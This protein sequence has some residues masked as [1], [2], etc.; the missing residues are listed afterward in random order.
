[1]H[2]IAIFLVIETDRSQ[3]VAKRVRALVEGPI[4][5]WARETAGYSIQDV[6]NKFKKDPELILAWESGEEMPFMGQL[7]IMADMFKRPISDFYLPAPPAERPL[8][9]DFR[10]PRG[11]IAGDYSPA[12]RKQ[13]RFACE[14][15]DITKDLLDD[16]GDQLVHFP[17]QAR[18]RQSPER[19][20]QSIRDI[21]S[22]AA[23]EQITWKDPRETLNGW[24]QRIEAQNIL[25][26]Q[27]DGVDV[28]EA[29][30]FSIVEPVFPVIG[31]NKKLAPN[32]RTFTMLHE[33]THLLMGRSGI[34]DIDDYTQRAQADMEVE[35][36]C[37][38]AAAA[39]LMPEAEFRANKTVC[40]CSGPAV[41][42]SDQEIKDIASSFGV[43]R[44]AAVRRLLTFNLTTVDFYR[45]R[46]AEYH[47][48]LSAQKAR[49][50]EQ[51]KEKDFIGQSGPQRAISDFGS[52]YVR[53]ILNSLGEQRIT[54]ADAA[55]YLQVR[56]PA[57]RKVQ[58]LAL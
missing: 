11:A 4:L 50:R 25:V 42:W 22:V 1:Q 52:N 33:F 32:G 18:M 51:N 8:P 2:C 34:C 30:G 12:L 26:F 24:R 21:L 53:T 23:T 13:L 40:S 39:A 48:Q 20:G 58:E 17:H 43:S 49:E 27:F 36:F 45:E 10:R 56:A 14:R 47:A 35:V 28:E 54:L 38:H 37:N 7:R 44:E 55:Q 46:R 19:V 16:M 6:A 31:I 41:D 3:A 9:H 5:T 15:Q 57:V 29:W